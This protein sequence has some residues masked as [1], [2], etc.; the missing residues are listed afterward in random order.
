MPNPSM[1]MKALKGAANFIGDLG[2]RDRTPY[3]E[4]VLALEEDKRRNPMMRPYMPNYPP[5]GRVIDMPDYSQFQRKED[6]SRKLRDESRKLREL[7]RKHGIK[8]L[9]H[10]VPLDETI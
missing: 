7:M 9:S 2:A 10:S 8:I 1:L 4:F 3:E 5:S 6:E